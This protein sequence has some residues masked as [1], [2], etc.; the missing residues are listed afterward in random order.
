MPRYHLSQSPLYMVTSPLQ[1]TKRLNLD[2]DK[3]ERLVNREDNYVRFYIGTTK[4]RAV[5][6]PKERLWALQKR[7]AVWLSR[8]ETPGYL[9]SAVKGRSYITNAR[10]HR[11]DTNLIQV[12]IRSFFQNVTKHAVYMFFLNMMHCRRDVAML[13]AKALTVDE[14]LPTGSPVSPILSYFAHKRM[15][16]GIADLATENGLDF[17][18]YVDDICLS[19]ALAS[20]KMLFEVRRIIARNRLRSHK[21]KFFPAGIPRVVTG[22]ALT[23][24]GPRLPH[25][26]HLK[27]HEAFVQLK[28]LPSGTAYERELHITMSRMSEAAQLDPVWRDRVR[29][30][31]ALHTGCPAMAPPFTRPSQDT[32]PAPQRIS[33]DSSGAG[34]N[35]HHK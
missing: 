22:V 13:L 24:S 25:R 27:I 14:H 28:S 16:D 30:L 6:K 20:R 34:Q 11:A 31:R 9:N 21:C 15:F 12:D 1:L 32:H 5:Q 35:G 26:R 17:T 23:A 18:V 2:V 33:P 8:I 10:A 3:L 7:I 19:G 29:S 4:K